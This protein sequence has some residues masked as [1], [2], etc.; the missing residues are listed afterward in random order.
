MMQTRDR[1]LAIANPTL[2][3]LMIELGS[4]CQTVLALLNQLQLPNLSPDQQANILADLM[5]A[6]I[7]LHT[8]CGDEF[9]TLIADALEA[10]PDTDTAAPEPHD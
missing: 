7:H 5:A 10:L 4:E 6:S 1:P 3:T 8:H 2:N 9:Q